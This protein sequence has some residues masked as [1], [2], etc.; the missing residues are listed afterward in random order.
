M[1][2]LDCTA[3]CTARGAG[4]TGVATS[5][6]NSPSFGRGMLTSVHKLLG[7]FQGEPAMEVAPRD[8]AWQVQGLTISAPIPD[9]ATRAVPILEVSDT[10]H[11]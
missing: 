1:D 7:V 8:P 11:M 2:A 5:A 9:I 4:Q 10:L 3:L 6:C